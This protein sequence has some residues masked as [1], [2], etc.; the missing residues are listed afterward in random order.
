MCRVR[1]SILALSANDWTGPWM[2]RQQLLSRLARRG[3]VVVY[4]NGPLS[5]WERSTARWYGAGLL[6][7]VEVHSGVYVVRPGKIF[8]RCPRFRKWDRW[9]IRGH[10]RFLSRVLEQ[11][12]TGSF[13]CWVTHPKYLPYVEAVKPDKIVYHVYDAY[14]LSGEWTP[15]LA[16]AEKVVVAKA[17][18]IIAV[19]QRM[20]DLLPTGAKILTKILPNGAD[21]EAFEQ[22]PELP[23]PDDLQGIPRPRI[24]YIGNITPKVDIDLVSALAQFHSEWQWVFV[25]SFVRGAED[26]GGG[27]GFEKAW[28]RCIE[29]PN[30]HHLGKKGPEDLPA[31]VG[32]MDVNVMCYKSTGKGWWHAGYPLKLHEYLAAGRPV[33]SADLEAIRPFK[34]VVAIARNVED[35]ER[36]IKEAIRGK[37][38]S[39]VEERRAVARQNSWDARVD[40]LEKSLLSLMDLESKPAVL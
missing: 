27:Q 22:G 21:V 38:R 15:E 7:Q 36:C 24:G 34:S 23:C 30:V 12:G 26:V 35:W 8:C 25:G 20:A 4:D 32:H 6:P 28:K 14:S 16:H 3:W 11:N 39:T 2:N 1:G 5:I 31:Y 13:L 18:L 29:L 10:C 9:A 37:G 17:D 40:D 33:I 19:T